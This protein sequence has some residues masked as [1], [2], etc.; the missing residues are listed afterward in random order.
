MITQAGIATAVREVATPYGV[1]LLEDDGMSVFRDDYSDG[2]RITLCYRHGKRPMYASAVF[3]VMELDAPGISIIQHEVRELCTRLRG[4][5]GLPADVPIVECGHR[6]PEHGEAMI[7]MTDSTSWTLACEQFVF[8]DGPNIKLHHVMPPRAGM[9]CST[10][11]TY[12]IE[13][14]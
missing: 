4:S 12:L 11:R 8:E 5:A 7:V 3:D 14:P 9:W 10:A 1:D 6:C 13:T 2:W